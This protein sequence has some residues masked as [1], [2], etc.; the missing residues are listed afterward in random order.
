MDPITIALGLAQIAPTIVRWIAGDK[1]GE[2]AQKVVDVATRVTG[3]SDPQS[4][5]DAISKDPAIALQF[6]Q[7]WLAQEVSMYQEETKRLETVNQTMR[8]EVASGDAYV[9]RMRPTWGYAL[10]VAFFAQMMAIAYVILFEPQWAAEVI[11]SMA[12]LS[13]IW[14]VGL[15]VLGVYVYKR[16]D[17]KKIA[18]GVPQNMGV[19]TA[20]AERIKGG[21][22]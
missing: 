14:G 19:F 3:I 21:Q 7:A 12:A 17:E 8:V 13:T 18:A 11:N 22:P 1:A 6:Q 9:R 20:I 16:S 2:N 10:C 5:A 15:A 4:A